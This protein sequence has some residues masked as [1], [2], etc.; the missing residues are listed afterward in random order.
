MPN[1]HAK[2]TTTVSRQGQAVQPCVGR[3]CENAIVSFGNAVRAESF[4]FYRR[5][6]SAVFWLGWHM[7][8]AGFTQTGCGNAADFLPDQRQH[9]LQSPDI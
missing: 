5:F 9:W 7:S 1:L 8:L 2:L 3:R 6:R 4:E